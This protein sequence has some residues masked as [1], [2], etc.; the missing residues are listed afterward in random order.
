M[1]CAELN[2]EINGEREVG[3]GGTQTQLRGFLPSQDL[4]S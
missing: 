4:V 2:Q 1:K 3:K